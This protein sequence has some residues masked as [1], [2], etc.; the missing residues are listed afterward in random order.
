[1][2]ALKIQRK[3]SELTL[4]NTQLVPK[5]QHDAVGYALIVF[6]VSFVAY[7]LY[8][9]SQIPTQAEIAKVV[10]SIQGH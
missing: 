10:M 5:T 1:M 8:F 4:V 3:A 6:M 9:M 2:N 7:G